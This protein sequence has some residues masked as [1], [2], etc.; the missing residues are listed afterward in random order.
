MSEP[1]MHAVPLD[2]DGGDGGPAAWCL[3]GSRKLKGETAAE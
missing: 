2:L 1:G 3:H